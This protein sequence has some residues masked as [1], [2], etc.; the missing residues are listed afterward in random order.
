MSAA[1]AALNTVEVLEE[2]LLYCSMQDLFRHRRTS[3]LWNDTI[4]ESPRIRRYLFLDDAPEM[5][6]NP[7]LLRV[8]R[9]YGENCLYRDDLGPRFLRKDASWRRMLPIQPAPSIMQVIYMVGDVM[10]KLDEIR[11]KDGDGDGDGDGNG[12]GDGGGGGDGQMSQAF[13]RIYFWLYPDDHIDELESGQLV[14][15]TE[16]FSR[17]TAESWT[18][19]PPTKDIMRIYIDGVELEQ[20]RVAII[21]TSYTIRVF[22]Q[23]RIF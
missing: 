7:V 3:R 14:P 16:S 23:N 17:D 2:I 8:L 22:L 18:W 5:E 1:H 20:S 9:P 11:P 19:T 15:C 10:F 12:D 13:K 21:E 4:E 6:L